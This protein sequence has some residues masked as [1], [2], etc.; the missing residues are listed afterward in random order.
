MTD[1]HA[2]A[3]AQALRSQISAAD[4]AYY[5]LDVRSSPTRSTTGSC[6]S[7]CELEAAHPELATPDSPTVRVGGVSSERFARVVHREPML[8]LG[9]IQ[10]DEELDELDARVHRLLG[11][12]AEDADPLG[13]RAEARRA[14]GRARLRGRPLRPGVHP[15]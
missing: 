3:R 8:S 10:T 14:G 6:A 7:S 9:N 4:H 12:A 15:R 5:V 2:A 13:G 11:L 1:E